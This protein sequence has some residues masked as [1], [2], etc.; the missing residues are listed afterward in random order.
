MTISSRAASLAAASLLVAALGGCGGGGGADSSAS[1]DGYDGPA[2]CANWSNG[3]KI[4][5]KLKLEG[6]EDAGVTT[7]ASAVCTD[8]SGE[9]LRLTAV[10]PVY[11]ILGQPAKY[12][13]K[14]EDATM[15]PEWTKLQQD[16]TLG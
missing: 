16:C 3:E 2:P 5:E 12:L 8:D 14:G 9:V 10:G 6:C 13:G 1:D 11:G 4:T 15:S 7:N